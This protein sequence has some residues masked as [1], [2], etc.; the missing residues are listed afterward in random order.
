[1]GPHL[2]RARQFFA[3]RLRHSLQDRLEVSHLEPTLLQMRGRLPTEPGESAR[4]CRNRYGTQCNH[5]AQGLADPPSPLVVLSYCAQ[6]RSAVICCRRCST[7]SNSSSS[8]ES[9]PA[10]LSSLSSLPAGE[11]ARARPPGDALLR[12]PPPCSTARKGSGGLRSERQWRR[13]RKAV[14]V[15]HGIVL[16]VGGDGAHDVLWWISRRLPHALHLR[17]TSAG[18]GGRVKGRVQQGFAQA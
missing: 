17:R 8:S 16:V 2:L 13:K 3:L 7:G 6:I 14:S 12:L 9:L 15:S 18:G 11:V 10:W 4:C 5:P 1:M